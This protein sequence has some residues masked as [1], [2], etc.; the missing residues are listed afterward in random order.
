MTKNIENIKFTYIPSLRTMAGDDGC[1]TIGLNDFYRLYVGQIQKWTKNGWTIC[2]ENKDKQFLIQPQ[3]TGQRCSLNSINEL[4][5]VFCIDVDCKPQNVFGTA[6]E[7]IS[8]KIMAHIDTIMADSPFI[9]AQKSISDGIHI[10]GYLNAKPATID[11][12]KANSRLMTALFCKKVQSVLNV[13]LTALDGKKSASNRIV[14]THN[15]SPVQLFYV[16]PTR[17]AINRDFV[18]ITLDD[19]QIASLKAAYPTIFEGNKPSKTTKSTND[20]DVHYMTADDYHSHQYTVAVLKVKKFP[21]LGDSERFRIAASLKTLLCSNSITRI[22]AEQIY[23]HIINQNS[24]VV[25]SKE[26]Q[27]NKLHS[28]L[29]RQD[30]KP[31]IHFELLKSVGVRVL[32]V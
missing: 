8:D 32:S 16:S 11:E 26:Q 25:D 21:H 17:M 14:D 29:A 2:K 15:V 4:S 5:Q 31:Q 30:V 10:I 6:L 3:P 27:I 7:G 20:G 24:V 19:G 23:S 18:G 1:M 12:Y 28:V 13:N 9:F 22:Q